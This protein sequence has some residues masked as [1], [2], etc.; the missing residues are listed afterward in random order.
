L[1]RDYVDNSRCSNINVSKLL[2][3]PRALS[4]QEVLDLHDGTTFDY[5]KYLVASYDMSTVNPRDTS[6]HG[7]DA[8]GVG[9]GS[10]NIV[11]G[12]NSLSKAISFNGVDE[13]LTIINNDDINFTTEMSMVACFNP[14]TITSTAAHPHAII[15]KNG[16]IQ[17]QMVYYAPNDFE[18]RFGN[19]SLI[20]NGLEIG[21]FNIVGASYKNGSQ[22]VSLNGD[23]VN[24]GSSLMVDNSSSEPIYIGYGT[25]GR[26]NANA[27]IDNILFYNKYLTTIQHA[28]ISNRIRNGGL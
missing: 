10:S 26:V 27:I 3:F 14:I 9:I 24:I 21:T 11:D 12:V 23:L 28:D 16:Y 18:C 15:S 20:Q 22:L 4:S 1:G 2:V 5:D 7:N 6:G 13:Y 25:L 8:V 17:Y 19:R